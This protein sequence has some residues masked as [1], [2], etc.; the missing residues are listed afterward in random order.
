MPLARRR[1]PV[2]YLDTNV[3][4]DYIRKRNSDSV[5]LL[6][7]IRKRRLRSWTSFYSLLELT[8]KELEN[9]WI[10]KRAQKGETFDDILR[11]RYPR[12]LSEDELRAV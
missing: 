1:K 3:I 10:W 11:S 12:K 5:G 2:P 9:K 7:T 6:E 8:D 4:L